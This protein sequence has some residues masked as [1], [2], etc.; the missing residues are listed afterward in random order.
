MASRVGLAK[1]RPLTIKPIINNNGSKGGI[2]ELPTGEYYNEARE[3]EFW[4]RIEKKNEKNTSE[5]QKKVLKQTAAVSDLHDTSGK[6]LQLVNRFD[7]IDQE[8]MMTLMQLYD[9]G[10]NAESLDQH[11]ILNDSKV[12]VLDFMSQLKNLSDSQT[13]LVENL[14]FWF[15]S[16]QQRS[17]EGTVSTIDEPPEVDDIIDGLGQVVKDFTEK[18]E[19]AACVHND[20][21]DFMFKQ[22][23]SFKRV[24]IQKDD[25]IKKLQKT[26]DDYSVAAQARRAKK[27]QEEKPAEEIIKRDQFE[28]Q[29]RLNQQMKQQIDQLKRALHETEVQKAAIGALSSHNPDN[30]H[31]V[32]EKEANMNSFM[33]EAEST[34]AVQREK[35]EEMESYN[36]TLKSRLKEAENQILHLQQKIIKREQENAE[37]DSALQKQLQLY[38]FEK[39]QPHPVS[40]MNVSEDKLK[41][42]AEEEMYIIQMKHQEEMKELNNR[43]RQELINQA[44]LSRLRYVKERQDL[45]NDFDNGNQN[46]IFQ[47][48]TRD[49]EKRI[50]AMKREN[51]ELNKSLASEFASRQAVLIRQYENRIHSINE[52]HQVDLSTLRDSLKFEKKKAELDYEEKLQLAIVQMGQEKQERFID[53]QKHTNMLQDEIDKKNSE[54]DKLNKQLKQ[55]AISQNSSRV[56]SPELRLIAPKSSSYVANP[57]SESLFQERKY[58]FKLKAIKE[59]M[60]D[61]MKWALEK[62]KLFYE[63]EMNNIIITHQKDLRIKLMNLQDSISQLMESHIGENA[64]SSTMLEIGE[65]FKDMNERIE[66]LETD[67]LLPTISIQEAANRTQVLTDR[68]IQLRGENSD[69][70]SSQAVFGPN[71]EQLQQQIRLLESLQ[72]DDEKS[73]ADRFMEKDR[74]HQEE[75]KEKDEIIAQLYG[76]QQTILKPSKYSFMQFVVYSSIPNDL[77]LSLVFESTSPIHGNTPRNYNPNLLISTKSIVS[78]HRILRNYLKPLTNSI[79]SSFHIIEEEIDECQDNDLDPNAMAIITRG[80]SQFEIFN[81]RQLFLPPETVISPNY[82]PYMM[83]EGSQTASTVKVNRTLYD[84]SI[85]A[86]TFV[87]RIVSQIQICDRKELT[88]DL[89]LV[90]TMGYQYYDKAPPCS[91]TWPHDIYTKEP[92]IAVYKSLSN[93]TA[94]HSPNPPS[95]LKP[96][97]SDH[98]ERIENIVTFKEE[99][100]KEARGVSYLRKDFDLFST[101][102][103]RKVYTRKEMSY[104]SYYDIPIDDMVGFR[105][106][107]FDDMKTRIIDSNQKKISLLR[108]EISFLKS[109]LN[110]RTETQILIFNNPKLDDLPPPVFNNAKKETRKQDYHLPKLPSKNPEIPKDIQ[111]DV[112][113]N[114]VENNSSEELP[115]ETPIPIIS[116]EKKGSNPILSLSS[117]NLSQNMVS[118][119]SKGFSM[120][121]L[122]INKDPFSASVQI[123]SSS[124]RMLNQYSQDEEVIFNQISNNTNA[125]DAYITASG[126]TDEAHYSF[127]ESLKVS[128]RQYDDIHQQ[129]YYMSSAQSQLMKCLHKMKQFYNSAQAELTEIKNSRAQERIIQQ[130][131]LLDQLHENNDNPSLPKAMNQLE[132]LHRLESSIELIDKMGLVLDSEKQNIRDSL[133]AQIAILKARLQSEKTVNDDTIQKIINDV[134]MFISSMRSSTSIQDNKTEAPENLNILTSD[135]RRIRRQR[136]QL[137]NDLKQVQ[138]KNESLI[139]QVQ[140]LQERIEEI[141]SQKQDELSETKAHLSTL[142]DL[143]NSITG[144]A[145]HGSV[146]EIALNVKKQFLNM[147][148]ILEASNA[149]KKLF[150]MKATEAED[151]LIIANETIQRLKD[152]VNELMN[153]ES[154]PSVSKSSIFREAD[155]T[156]LKEERAIDMEMSIR[157]QEQLEVTTAQNTELLAKNNELENKLLKL[158]GEL[159]Q[160]NMRISELEQ[161]LSDIYHHSRGTKVT[162]EKPK[163][164][165]QSSPE[166]KPIIH[167]TSRPNE[168]PEVHSVID[169]VETNRITHEQIV[170]NDKSE[171]ESISSEIETDIPKPKTPPPPINTSSPVKKTP[172]ISRSASENNLSPQKNPNN[173]SNNPSNERFD[174]DLDSFG[175]DF[176][177]TESTSQFNA[178][179][180]EDMPH[181]V[182]EPLKWGKKKKIRIPIVEHHRQTRNSLI[183]RLHH[184][185]PSNPNPPRS[186]DIDITIGNAVQGK[187]SLP[188]TNCP[189]RPTSSI[190][191]MTAAVINSL[192]KKNETEVS[193]ASSSVI[194]NVQPPPQS[195]PEKAQT[196]TRPPIEN[197]LESDPPIPMR[198][199]LVMNKKDP[200][201]EKPP[202]LMSTIPPFAPPLPV[203]SA[204][205]TG[206]VG[207]PLKTIDDAPE[208]IEAKKIISRLREQIKKYVQ[209]NEDCDKII[210]EQRQKISDLTLQLHRLKLDNI[211]HIDNLKRSQIKSDN[212]KSRLEICFREIGTRD[213]DIMKLKREIL[214]LKNTTAPISELNSK[215]KQAQLEKDR[216]QREEQKRNEV[217]TVAENA[218]KNVTNLETKQH[219]DSIIERTQASIARLEAKKKMWAEIEKKNMIEVLSAMS[220][221]ADS[222]VESVTRVLP[223]YSPFRSNRIDKT[224]S[225]SSRTEAAKMPRTNEV[226]LTIKPVY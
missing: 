91:L 144:D 81:S 165:E 1:I 72:T 26:I 98:I 14:R 160:A 129:I 146:E 102:P 48:I 184:P 162:N 24:I 63:R 191:G 31:E 207:K 115:K 151:S 10:S 138:T 215:I 11:I 206:I 111:A 195:I 199:T 5:M 57:E 120:P 116:T 122:D 89:V 196:L 201:K 208:M 132:T 182:H 213:D 178:F 49:Y 158:I 80:L 13:S 44:E 126:L 131:E 94:Y 7:D 37:L 223:E 221:L 142:Q 164:K 16:L 23:A 110:K 209:Q 58:T 2:A 73:I 59:E 3:A 62:Q 96:S 145:L 153:S 69:L 77:S 176:N 86:K 139:Q 128:K 87:N 54:I 179:D 173:L 103:Y 88:R 192:P 95:Q 53:F 22:F 156:Q 121:G 194:K 45:L 119:S 188:G 85:Q 50:E 143:L 21:T 75:L 65:V 34:I 140:N 216:I 180:K 41:K 177:P 33:V 125:Y 220:L 36:A 51:E 175:Y 205:S 9:D 100:P 55:N 137:K 118:P 15:T 27:K 43:H 134:Q 149:E 203:L 217:K 127:V 67:P 155:F 46:A 224:R 4:E 35:M 18:S 183:G 40:I 211:K 68:L 219:L 168:K 84:E 99:K 66:T 222:Q 197:T 114:T 150:S 170:N 112:S 148:A 167:T 12:H 30:S 200:P 104:V 190:A 166:T 187:R 169:K 76:L 185:T 154:Y 60:E 90:N 92:P 159:R 70:K 225:L 172:S 181:L 113:N 42:Q 202:L 64:L 8:T 28:A 39:S 93:F 52:A 20:I 123:L 152:Q 61:Q 82:R 193:L 32:L 25:D 135:L 56:D 105:K 108:Q 174:V 29:L 210:I 47:T 19:K 218:L 198:I 124:L 79:T 147:E 117:S 107:L 74:R 78:E 17:Q 133:L 189:I 130:Q 157:Q 171:N 97:Y 204:K 71:I 161:Q 38:S 6:I 226:E 141:K 214:H 136:D 186:D 212:F 101:H 83:D 109:E 106:H 163:A